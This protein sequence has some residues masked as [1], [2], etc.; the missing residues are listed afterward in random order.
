M[1]IGYTTG[2]FASAAAKAAVKALFSGIFSD[3]VTVALPDSKRVD[4]RVIRR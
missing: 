1:K 4:I 2:T 3:R